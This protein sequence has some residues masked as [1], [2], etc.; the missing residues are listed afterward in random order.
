MAAIKGQPAPKPSAVTKPVP[1]ADDD[2]EVNAF[3]DNF[4]PPASEDQEVEAVLNSVA[5]ASAAV[6]AQ[7]SPAF[8][9]PWYTEALPVVG[10]IVGG[11][12]GAPAGPVGAVGGATLGG[13]AGQSLRDIIETQL[14]G[15]PQSYGIDPL[16][17]AG[18]AGLEEG[19]GQVIGGAITKGAGKA[20]GLLDNTIAKPVVDYMKNTVKSIRDSVEEPL[21]KIIANKATPMNVEEAGNS[22]KE[23]LKQNIKA[24]YGPFTQAYSDLDSI[25]KVTPI[26]EEARSSFVNGLKS[27]A[28][29]DLAGDNQR[30]VKKFANDVVTAKSG[31]QLDDLVKQIGDA[32]RT[33]FAN[34]ATAQGQALKALE[35][36]AN[37]FFEQETTKLATRIQS[38]KA[39][40]QEINFLNQL[41]QQRG[42]V[43]QDPTK[44]AQSLAKDYLSAKDKIKTDYAGF[45]SFLDDVSEQ[46]KIRADKKGPMTF[47]NSIDEVPSEKLI[48]RMFDPKNAA[49]LRKMQAETPEVF[50]TVAK[51]KVSQIIQKSSPDGTIDLKKLR[52]NIYKMPEPSRKLL[53][54]P[55]DLLALNKVVDDPRLTRLK[56]LEK[57]GNNLVANWL[58]QAMAVGSLGKQAV[59][60]SKPAMSGIRQVIGRPLVGPAEQMLPRTVGEPGE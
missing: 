48:E 27:W 34:N 36:R 25:A 43:E 32:K 13:A 37:N 45:R 44:Y 31:M 58:K 26:D 7:E 3:L 1:G 5:P 14:L 49:A 51:S 20:L 29:S 47:L 8:E 15:K 12:V 59:S 9:S 39:S 56:T 24:K 21:M 50:D 2:A 52:A 19:A 22:A 11:I 40:P 30:I 4:E 6:E 54:T 18:K 33:A 60:Q 41:M 16:V 10:G 55:D 46:T 28:D 57:V 35:E 53:F 23:L 42:V 17:D 38:G